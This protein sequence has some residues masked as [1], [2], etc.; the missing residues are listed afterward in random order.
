VGKN[1]DDSFNE[2]IPLQ[3]QDT[4]HH[5]EADY[6]RAELPIAAQGG[7][8]ERVFP[9]ASPTNHYYKFPTRQILLWLV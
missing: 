7:G 6:V 3:H 5:F 9:A 1:D 2:K 8:G 4:Y